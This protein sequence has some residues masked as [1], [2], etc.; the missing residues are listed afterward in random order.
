MNGVLIV[1]K[2]IGYTSRDVVNIVS[3]ELNTKK[4]GHTG[5]LDPLASGVLVL[6][7]GKALKVAELI[8]S[9]DKEY[10]AKVRLGYETDTLDREGNIVKSCEYKYF[11]KKEIES[12]LQKFIGKIKQEVPKYSAVKVNGKKLYE[13]ARAG[14][15]VELPIHDVEIY[16]LDIVGDIE[17][18]NG[19]L[20]FTIKC[21]VSKGTYIRS[22]VRDIGV[23]LGVYATMVSLRRVRQGKFDINNSYT[24]SDIK[25]GN[26]EIKSIID[27][28]DIDK[29][30]VDDKMAFKVK[31]GQVLDKF[32]DNDKAM[33]LN[34]SNELLAIYEQGMNNK[35]KPFKVF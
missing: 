7:I 23:S 14:I 35:V 28:L 27:I 15:E 8:T 12:V 10:I 19:Y 4:I 5:T 11:T 17:N 31:N 30:M 26:Y 33:I 34:S 22:L 3:K 29:I 13:Y 2:N 9:Y 32:F 21:T 6:C 25:S 20:E 1:D 16:S 18:S 24:I